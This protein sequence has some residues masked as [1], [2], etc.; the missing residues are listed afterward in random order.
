M[1]GETKISIHYSNDLTIKERKKRKVL[2]EELK[3]RK[4]ENNEKDIVIRGN[5]IVKLQKSFPEEA[6]PGL[7]RSWADLFKQG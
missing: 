3:R 1:D 7:H 4:E 5:K 6:Q 2:V